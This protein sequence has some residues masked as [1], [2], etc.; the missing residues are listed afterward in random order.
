[1]ADAGNAKGLASAILYGVLSAALTFLNKYVMKD[2]PFVTLLLLLQMIVTV[3]ALRFLR[4]LNI[5]ITFPNYSFENGR[6]LLLPSFMYCANIMCALTALNGLSVPVY[7][8]L[9]RMTPVGCLVAAYFVLSRTPS[10]NVCLC[11]LAISAG[12]VVMGAGDINFNIYGYLL[13]MGSVLSQATYLTF[14][15]KSGISKDFDSTAALYINAVNCIPIL[16]LIT[17]AD[18]DLAA[19]ALHP[20]LRRAD[21]WTGVSVLLLAGACLNY[22][23]FLCTMLNS[24][25]AT[26]VVGV[27]KAVFVTILGFFVFGGQP[28][29][30]LLLLGVTVNT[31]GAACYAVVKCHEKAHASTISDLP[32]LGLLLQDREGIRS[33]SCAREQTERD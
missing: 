32:D 19:L 4:S 11:V 24:A 30:R 18:S 2:F 15:E 13:G 29:T 20:N 10:R 5:G 7:Q 1:M 26:T 6:L 33:G 23:M 25:V 9:K 27:I 16:F 22:S 3:V 28:V 31:L 12:T 8:V 21:V 17:V 14:I